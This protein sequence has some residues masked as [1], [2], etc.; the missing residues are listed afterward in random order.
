MPPNPASSWAYFTWTAPTA[1][2]LLATSLATDV[3]FWSSSPPFTPGQFE[4]GAVADTVTPSVGP[5]DWEFCD[6]AKSAQI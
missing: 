3:V 4:F 1:P 6:P 5:P 2:A